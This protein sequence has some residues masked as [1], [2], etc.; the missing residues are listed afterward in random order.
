MLT[1]ALISKVPTWD[2]HNKRVLLRADL[3]VPLKNGVILNDYRLKAILPTLDM[4][5]NKGGRVI[6]ATHIGRPTTHTAQLSTRLL[7]P[8]FKKYGYSVIYHH[9]IEQAYHASLSDDAAIILLENMRFFPGEKDGDSRFIEAL[10]QLGDYYVNDAFALLHRPDSSITRVPLLFAPEKR[11]IGLLIEKELNMLNRLIT[12]PQKPFTLILGGGKVADK[13]PLLRSIVKSVTHIIL[14]PAIV[15]TF[16]K[17]LGK[18]VGRSLIDMSLLSECQEILAHAKN[19]NV[20][21]LFPVD[22]IVAEHSFNGPL[23]CVDEDNFPAH[24]VGITIGPRSGALFAPIIK[25]SKTIFCNGLMG[26]LARP[27][28]L[29]GMASLLESI[30]DSGAYSVIGGGDSVGLVESLGYEKDITYISTGG[31]ATLAYLAKMP[32]PGLMPFYDT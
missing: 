5:L 30:K 17:A 29:S 7:V 26:D 3:N 25:N 8:W 2:L 19:N 12:N 23:S 11:S 1:H 16:L 9:D 13:L 15:F 32:L 4:I 10:A 31:G 14:G 21:I 24:A 22:Y 20:S 27:E 28:T 6:L 18:P